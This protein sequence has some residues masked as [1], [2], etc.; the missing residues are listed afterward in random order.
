MAMTDIYLMTGSQS[1]MARSLL[2][3]SREKLAEEANVSRGTICAFEDDSAIR[4]SIILDIQSVFDAHGVEF[5]ADGSVR[6]RS[7]GVKDFRGLGSCDR[8]FANINK[9]L[10]E[11]PSEIICMI[12]SQNM[13]TKPTG[14]NG[15]NNFE[16]LQELSKAATV[17]CLLEDK[18]MYLPG[19]P[20]FEVK[21]NQEAPFSP[22]LSQFGYGEELS[23]AFEQD[24]RFNFRHPVYGILE[25]PYH[26]KKVS[27]HFHE[28][29]SDAQ[30]YA[31]PLSTR[32]CKNVMRKK[33]LPSGGHEGLKQ[34]VLC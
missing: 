15:L 17:K 26:A 3:W 5:L 28:R 16:R 1:R 6:P 23:F 30:P 11:K 29:W 19:T 2:K 4:E 24:P 8:F 18:H 31:T 25:S 34:Q 27:E 12:A 21:V 14:R 7:D 9:V 13:L 20:S 22:F 33:M 10:A 32:A